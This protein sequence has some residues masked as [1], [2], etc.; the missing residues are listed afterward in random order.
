MIFVVCLFSYT[1]SYGSIVKKTPVIGITETQKIL[2][3]LGYDCDI[4]GING[5]KTTQAVIAFQQDHNL[6][7]DGIVGVKTQ[8]GLICSYLLA[9]VPKVQNYKDRLGKR[10]IIYVESDPN[11]QNNFYSMYVGSDQGTHTAVWFKFM[12]RKDM[13]EILVYDPVHDQIMSLDH[14]RHSEAR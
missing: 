4:D 10:F 5:G 7:A 8:D 13:D 11:E 1:T 9:S 6:T 2:D 3:K 12:I 14:W